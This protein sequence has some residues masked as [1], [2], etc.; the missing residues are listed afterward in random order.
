MATVTVITEA[1]QLL[2]ARRSANSSKSSQLTF[3]SSSERGRNEG[4]YKPTANGFGRH[5]PSDWAFYF[6]CCLCRDD[7]KL[8]SFAKVHQSQCVHLVSRHSFGNQKP[9]L[10]G[11]DALCVSRYLPTQV[12]FVWDV[13]GAVLQRRMM[14]LTSTSNIL[15]WR[16]PT[17][18]LRLSRVEDCY[19]IRNLLHEHADQHGI[20]RVPTWSEDKGLFFAWNTS[21]F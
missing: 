7:I 21:F 11:P 10:F 13:S 3:L 17:M 20:K 15:M 18:Q 16:Q 14:F 9:N 4:R 8:L 12:Y 19:R 1:W 2:P 5:G 6:L